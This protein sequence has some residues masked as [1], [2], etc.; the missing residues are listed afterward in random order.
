MRKLT[1]FF[2]IIVT[3]F[4]LQTAQAADSI[5]HSDTEEPLIDLVALTNQKMETSK[6]S[7]KFQV[8]VTASDNLNKLEN[9]WVHVYRENSTGAVRVNNVGVTSGLDL[10]NPISVNVI[11]GRVISIYQVTIELPMGFA[12]GN[13]YIYV[14]AKDRAGNYPG[15]TDQKQ[16]YCV[17]TYNRS[18][19]EARFV[20]TND[21]SGSVID[22]TEFSLSAKFADLE[23]KYLLEKNTTATLIASLGN[24]KAKLEQQIT[25]L[26]QSM[27]IQKNEIDSLK[28][29]MTTICK[30]KPK[31]KGC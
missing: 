14:F 22:V 11:N 31:P 8:T 28:K 1:L 12:A 26:N 5:N 6:S 16:K 15:C 4:S 17:Y 20:V 18:L 30:S 7:N 23:Q 21:G 19:P 10:S 25:A 29:K 24:E 3:V 13:Y 27:S 2:L 9:I